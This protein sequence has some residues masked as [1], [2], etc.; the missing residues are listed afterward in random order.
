MAGAKYKRKRNRGILHGLRV[1]EIGQRI[2]GPVVGM[3]LAEQGAEV[4]RIVDPALPVFDPVLDALL[5]RGK[6]ELPVDL[7]SEEGCDALRRLVREADVV[8]ENRQ[9]G[10]MQR[11]GLDFDAL[12]HENW[13][14]RSPIQESSRRRR[15]GV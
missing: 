4:V 6:T 13:R 12:R 9:P 14:Q 7:S 8:V 15:G 11:L 1:V 10:T 5:A 3:L 2:A